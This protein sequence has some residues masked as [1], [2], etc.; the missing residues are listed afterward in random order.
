MW[1]MASASGDDEFEPYTAA[2]I[3]VTTDTAFGEI[4]LPDGGYSM[5]YEMWDAMGNY[6]YSDAVTFDCA[7]GEIITTV[8][9]D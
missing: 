1:Y 6:A 2:T 3:T 7:N 4:T 5:V 8:Y 9:E